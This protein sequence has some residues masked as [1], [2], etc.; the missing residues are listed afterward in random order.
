MVWLPGGCS[1]LDT[2]DPKPEASSEYR[3]PFRTIPTKIP[4]V[5]FTELLPRQAARAVRRSSRAGSSFTLSGLA[6]K[7]SNPA[8]ST[9]TSNR[10]Q[11]A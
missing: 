5:H 2:Y 3:G 6:R 11:R 4:G 9:A 8:A 7:P 1:Q 10:R